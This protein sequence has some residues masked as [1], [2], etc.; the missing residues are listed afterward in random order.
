MIESRAN[1]G[2]AGRKPARARA[3]NVAAAKQSKNYSSGPITSCRMEAL[4]AKFSDLKFGDGG[5]LQH[6]ADCPQTNALIESPHED[7]LSGTTQDLCAFGGQVNDSGGKTRPYCG[8]YQSM[9]RAAS[10]V[11]VPRQGL[12]VVGFRPTTLECRNQ[13]PTQRGWWT[14]YERIV[15]N[16]EVM[17]LNDLGKMMRW[18]A[19]T[20]S[21]PVFGQ[22]DRERNPGGISTNT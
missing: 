15:S 3:V 20:R 5:I 18:S 6:R 12:V 1:S 9:A 21:L 10:F 4:N 17:D 22:G 11:K 7:P 14:F 13:A 8:C 16:A 2:M 19:S